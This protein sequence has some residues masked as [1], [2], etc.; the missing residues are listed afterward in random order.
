MRILAGKTKRA[1]VQTKPWAEG[2]AKACI[3]AVGGLRTK[4]LVA[5]EIVA[6]IMD[7]S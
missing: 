2:V 5:I 6:V 3:E 7:L 4:A 1:E